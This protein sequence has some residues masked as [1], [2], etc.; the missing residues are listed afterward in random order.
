MTCWTSRLRYT[1]SASTGRIWAA[2]LRG[3]LLRLHAVLRAGLL[4][5]AHS[6][7]VE[8]SPD[9]LV[10]ESRQILDPATAH[11]HD[12][13]LLE[14]VSFAG[15]VGAD[16][17]AVREPHASDLPERRVGLLGRRRVD[18]RADAAS[19]WRCDLLLAA[20]A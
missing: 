17:H 11:E 19:L 10:A 12:G 8:R 1:G 15:N 5:V 14:V 9:H 16:F 4:A 3:K 18:A 6:C 7:C 20:L 13:V 2:A